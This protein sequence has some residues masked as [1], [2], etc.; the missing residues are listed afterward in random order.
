MN[1]R[2]PLLLLLIFPPA[3]SADELRL[4]AR[5]LYDKGV[6]HHLR[7]SA[8]GASLE[9]EEGELF[10][11]DG[12]AAGFSYKP[13]EEKLSGTVWI[14]KEFILPNPQTRKATLLVG[15]GGNLQALVNGKPHELKK[16]G[17]AGNYWEMY[18]LAPE[19]LKAGK[20]DVVLFGAGKVWIARAEDF[21]AGSIE[22]AKHP[23][24]SAKSK[25]AGK[26]WDYD[27]LGPKD[28]LD[29]EYYVRLFLQRHQPS[30]TLL[31]PV[32]DAGNLSGKTIAPPLTSLAHWSVSHKT[33]LTGKSRI[34]LRAR[35]GTTPVPDEK[36]WTDWQ[37]L[38]G[39]GKPLVHRYLQVEVELATDDPLHTPQLK[40]I[41]IEVVPQRPADWTAKVKVVQAQNEEIVRSSIPFQYEPFGQSDLARLREQFKLD[42]VVK[43]AKTEFELIGKLAAWASKQWSKGHL[44]EIYPAWNALEILK[45]HTD[46]KP[47][48]G[49][50][51]HYNLTFL[52]AC[53]SFGIP[54]RAVSIGAGGFVDKP[55]KSGHEVVE[56][57][58]NEHKKWVYVDGDLAWYVIDVGTKRPLSLL[59]L[60]SRQLAGLI[61]GMLVKET[62]FVKVGESERA[63][64]WGSLEKGP[65]FGELRLI[66][67]SNFLEQ[68]APLPLNQGMRGWFWTGHHVWTD[69]DMPAALLYGNRVTHRR[70]WEWTLNQAHYTLEAT[71]T[72]GEI[73][74]HL[75][76]HTP[77]F[78][79]F[80]ADIDGKGKQPVTSGF[81][82]KLH[83]GTNRLEVWPRNDAGREGIVSRVV[84]DVP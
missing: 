65:A 53:E 31:L 61:P 4:K 29:G 30:G 37:P 7:L 43:G 32:F 67:R 76:T 17:K 8:D 9:L 51:Q 35:T 78:A 3:L 11:D 70:N 79:T 64:H 12:P 15:S 5:D 1:V 19:T 57:W 66:P 63:Q 77:G 26:T 45:A 48:G 58:S 73:R 46:G 54:G 74:V 16:I 24:R 56:I 55:S 2:V 39:A 41:L 71:A 59:E 81:L 83:S 22:R 23:N 44:S 68:R 49:F 52:Q 75:D 6:S 60:R 38:P 25:D 33:Q 28:D 47:V 14:K 40:E 82:W 27:R 20:N 72:P 84:L 62:E 69:S 50:C 13:N 10:E 18:E 42:D 36:N 34:G 21:A 80:L